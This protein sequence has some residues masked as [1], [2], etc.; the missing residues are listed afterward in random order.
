MLA[1]NGQTDRAL[2]D[3][4]ES[5]ATDPSPTGYLHL[6]LALRKAGKPAEAAEGLGKARSSGLRPG[7]IH[8]LEMPSYQ[9]LVA[10]FPE[11]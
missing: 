6:A 5:I 7:D 9:E 8:P 11:K 10:A 2:Q 4:E 1:L 3:L